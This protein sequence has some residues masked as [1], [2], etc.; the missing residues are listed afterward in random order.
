MKQK[1][2]LKLANM[3]KSQPDCFHAKHGLIFTS[4]ISV[5]LTPPLQILIAYIDNS[6]CTSKTILVGLKPNTLQTDDP[7]SNL[8]IVL[9]GRDGFHW[10][11]SSTFIVTSVVTNQYW[12]VRFSVNRLP[13]SQKVNEFTMFLFLLDIN[14]DWLHVNYTQELARTTHKS[15]LISSSMN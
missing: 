9:G 2:P 8:E 10:V 12:V 15:T 3:L 7:N 1:P 11:A 4:K 6:T 14:W 13:A 5:I